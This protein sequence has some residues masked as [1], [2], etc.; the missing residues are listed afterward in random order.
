M[1]LLSIVALQPTF[2]Q[3]QKCCMK[4]QLIQTEQHA[5]SH[6]LCFANEMTHYTNKDYVTHLKWGPQDLQKCQ[7]FVKAQCHLLINESKGTLALRFVYTIQPAKGFLTVEL[8]FFL[9][10]LQIIQYQTVRYDTLPLSPI[11][12]NRLSM[13]HSAVCHLFSDPSHMQ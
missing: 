2:L 12:R 7:L 6:L 11:S 9:F 10:Y 13:Y 8:F 1:C 4:W 5:H 3:L